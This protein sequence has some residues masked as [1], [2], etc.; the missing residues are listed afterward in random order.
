MNQPTNSTAPQTNDW[1]LY[2]VRG[3]REMVIARVRDEASIPPYVKTF[4]EEEIR[5]L[6]ENCHGCS[7]NA[8]G[9]THMRP[10]AH[11]IPRTIQVTVVGIVL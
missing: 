3:V 7:V 8:Y 6:P 11:E 9:Q 1:S 2:N 5:A 10:G 4:I